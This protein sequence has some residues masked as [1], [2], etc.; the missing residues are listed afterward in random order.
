MKKPILIADDDD[1][2]VLL[3][4]R[5]FQEARV[6]NPI[7]VVSTGEEAIRYLGGEGIYKDRERYP[8]PILFVL[9]LQMPR[10]NGTEVLAWLQTQNNLPTLR[11][12]IASGST[13]PRQLQQ[14]IHL[15]AQ[16]FL[17]KPPE[18]ENLL[19]ILRE[20]KELKIVPARDGIRLELAMLIA[21]ALIS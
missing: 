8:F 6:I 4:R 1:N 21:A 19:K 9:N 15:G 7:E 3:M 20:M 14:A 12:I 11:I 13:D 16:W 5:A 10:K 2:D 17:H 18:H